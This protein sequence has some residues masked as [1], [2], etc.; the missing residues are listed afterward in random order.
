MRGQLL[1]VFAGE[2]MTKAGSKESAEK[3]WQVK[4]RGPSSVKAAT[5]VTPEA[6]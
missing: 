5:T 1:E 2:I 3:D 6:K 4:P